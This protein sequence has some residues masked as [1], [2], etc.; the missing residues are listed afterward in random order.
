MYHVCRE[1][2]YVY[3]LICSLVALPHDAVDKHVDIKTVFP[4]GLGSCSE[5]FAFG[6][7]A[8]AEDF[9]L[10]VVADLVAMES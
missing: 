6:G 7:P 2:R 4:A 9:A 5:P 8:A 10:S 1:S 3:Y